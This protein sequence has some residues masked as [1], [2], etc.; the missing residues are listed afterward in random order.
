[1][2]TFE[3]FIRYVT[4]QKHGDRALKDFKDYLMEDFFRTYH[5]A[6]R[7]KIEKNADGWAQA[8][9]D[10]QKLEFIIDG[11]Y[12]D[13][14]RQQFR[15]F[16]KEEKSRKAKESRSKRKTVK[17]R[18]PRFNKKDEPVIREVIH[19]INVS[20]EQVKRRRRPRR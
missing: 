10:K 20:D 14:V 19:D 5:P 1:M 2:M 17:K 8:I 18:R 16:K 15:K 11:A 7:H 6:P 4:G 12:A 9:I 3:V 13:A